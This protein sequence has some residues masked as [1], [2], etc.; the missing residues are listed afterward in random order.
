MFWYAA[1]N[2]VYVY[3]VERLQAAFKMEEVLRLDCKGV[4][5]SD[6][7]KIGVKLKVLQFLYNYSFYPC[8]FFDDLNY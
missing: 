7:K 2:G 6:C 4:D 8:T 1:R 5:T 3:A